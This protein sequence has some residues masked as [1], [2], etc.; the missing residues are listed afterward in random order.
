M[1]TPILTLRLL[2]IRLSRDPNII[3]SQLNGA[4]DLARG[5]KD[6]F[7]A[8]DIDIQIF[9]NDDIKYSGIQLGSYR[10]VPEW[11]AIG[12][13]EVKALETWYDILKKANHQ[14]LENTVEI[15]EYYTPAFIDIQ[16]KYKIRS[17]LINDDLAKEFNEI[18]D[19]FARYDRMEKYIYGNIQSFFTHIGFVHDKNTNFLK[20][21]VLE[22]MNH[23][24]KAQVYHHQKKSAFSIT[25]LC[26]FRLPQTLRLGQSTALGY[27]KIGHK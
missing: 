14:P 4:K 20:I 11:T 6:L 15:R 16:K 7:D 13:K 26:N 12:E 24:Q 3:K 10:G 21:T 19:K 5:H 27:G 18:K 17:F 2:D 23:P 8:Q 22:M 9:H 1:P 25:F